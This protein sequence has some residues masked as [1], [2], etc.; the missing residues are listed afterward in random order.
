MLYK[1]KYTN[2]RGQS[3]TFSRA[4][5]LWISEFSLLSGT[6]VTLST[7]QSINQ[8]GASV[9]SQVVEPKTSTV[10][11]FI[12]GDGKTQ[13]QRIIDTVIPLDVGKIV[14]ND[15]YSIDVY[16]E[17]SPIVDLET[18]F[19]RFEFSVTAA[20]PFWER[21]VKTSVAMSGLF[22]LFK[23]PWNIT[24]TYKFGEMVNSYFTSIN[25]GGHVPTFYSIEI[26]SNGTTVNPVISNALTG[27]F[28]KL[29]KTLTV[30]ERINIDV[31]PDSL[32]VVSSTDGDIEGLIDIESDLF[33]L[34]VGDTTLKYDA[35]SGR[36]N[37]AVTLK[38]SDK[39]AGVVV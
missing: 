13:K 6:E 10:K 38:Y 12:Q 34:P 1:M 35:D 31:K 37:L 25:N 11:G 27:S 4:Q 20:Y 3:I 15:E 7:S 8:V 26:V 16:V 21:T 36:E 28:I 39:L 14:V 5:G 32:S 19:P 33:S 30:G 23:F 24:E 18:R 29:N 9:E 17:E 22:G 2:S